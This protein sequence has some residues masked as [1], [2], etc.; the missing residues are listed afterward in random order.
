[1]TESSSEPMVAST[2]DLEVPEGKTMTIVSGSAPCSIFNVVGAVDA[3]GDA[4]A[5]AMG[6]VDGCALTR[7]AADLSDVFSVLSISTALV[8]GMLMKRT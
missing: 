6:F 3:T 5:E 2:I 4:D 7:V 1:M 8:S